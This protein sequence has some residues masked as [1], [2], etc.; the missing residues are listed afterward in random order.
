MRIQT[1]IVALGVI[2]TVATAAVIVGLLGFK[3][4]G[5]RREIRSL[6]GQIRAANSGV[7]AKLQETTYSELERVNQIATDMIVTTDRNT[8]ANVKLNFGIAKD[9]IAELG[10]VHFGDE[11][12]EWRCVNQFSNEAVAVRLPKFYIGT[13]AIEP[14]SDPEDSSP[15]VDYVRYFTHDHCTIFQRMND[16]GDMVRVGTSILNRDGTRAVGTYIPRTHGDGTLDPILEK[17]LKGESYAGPSNILGAWHRGY[18]EPL[19]DRAREKVIGMLFVGSNVTALDEKIRA[20]LMKIKVAK[21]GNIYIIGTRG[22]ENGNYVLSRDGMR[23]G[24]NISNVKDESG[25]LV[26][27]DLM[28][29]AMAAK[30][31][32]PVLVSYGWRESGEQ[33]DR[34]KL[35][36]VSY[37]KDRGW[38]VGVSCYEEELIGARRMLESSAGEMTNSVEKMSKG[39]QSIVRW[40]LLAAIGLAGIS[41]GVGHRISQ[42]ICRPLARTAAI[43]EASDL[44]TRLPVDTEDEVGRMASAFNRMVEKLSVAMRQIAQNAMALSMSSQDLTR[45]SQSLG[46]HAEE[47]A[48]QANVVAAAC[49]QVSTNIQTVATGAE[50]MTASFCE[51]AKSTNEAV[52]VAS[53]AVRIAADANLTIENL[54]KSSREIGDV[55]KV[56][57][58]IAQQTNLLALNATIEAARAGEAGKG[59]A[60]VASEVKDLAKA[61]AQATENIGEKIATIQEAA[62]EAISAIT[63]I[64]STINQVNDIQICNASSVEEQS[65]TTN[66]MSRNLSEA[67]KGSLEIAQNITGVAEAAGGTT[68]AAG[69]TLRAAEELSRLSAE[70]NH[71]LSEFDFEQSS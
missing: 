19:W 15:V 43:L 48:A 35:S 38:V 1:K 60:V 45:V 64:T 71:L 30:D 20:S 46:G 58:S 7:I 10:V 17:V 70:L 25:R 28:R 34:T 22:A 33:H 40:S 51:I 31:G 12:V 68:T 27:Q 57:T 6:D 24:E 69:E 59:F 44:K 47:T 21:T 63:K 62:Y 14:K 53:G 16:N 61:T 49:E 29:R 66:E 18:Y 50:Q 54:G 37:Y 36:M 32:V 41:F 65:A 2:F 55:I 9:R 52:D 56:I 42:S 11:L 13:T 8:D 26:I 5:M 23:N 3:E 39:I 4:A 67:S